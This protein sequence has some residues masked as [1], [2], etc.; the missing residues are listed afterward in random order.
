MVPERAVT[1]LQGQSQVSIIDSDGRVQTR[2][3]K[4]GG[5]L[6]HSFVVESGLV[7]GERVITEGL[8]NILPGAKVNVRSASAPKPSSPL[9]SAE[10]SPKPEP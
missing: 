9:S 8:Q 5:Q 4:L 3:V 6:E 7:A 2:K 10:P 1:E